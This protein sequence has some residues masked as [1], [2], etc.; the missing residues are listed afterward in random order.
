MRKI[1]YFILFIITTL[2]IVGCSGSSE[3]RKKWNVEDANG[4]TYVM[5]ITDKEITI[6]N[7]KNKDRMTYTQNAKGTSNGIKYFGLIVNNEKFSII[8]PDKTNTDLALF[9]KIEND[10]YLSGALVYAMNTKGE[11]NYKEYAHKFLEK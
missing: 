11:P 7:E 5:D 4:N 8:F 6:S 3:I 1:K 2:L 9:L 10:D